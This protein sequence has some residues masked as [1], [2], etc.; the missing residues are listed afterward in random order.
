MTNKPKWG[1]Y[2]A[3]Q[4]DVYYDKLNIECATKEQ[5]RTWFMK[6]ERANTPCRRLEHF[7][8]DCLLA[9]ELKMTAAGK[10]AKAKRKAL[11]NAL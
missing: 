7:C 8:D 3:D 6:A 4:A 9:Y 11:E 2:T 10:C 5:Y 1:Q